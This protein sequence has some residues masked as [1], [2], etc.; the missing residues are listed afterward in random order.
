MK[1]NQGL[2]IDSIIQ[3]LKLNNP[4]YILTNKSKEIKCF[5]E[6]ANK[7]FKQNLE[8]DKSIH[9]YFKN[10][11]L[12]DLDKSKMFFVSSICETQRFKF[13]SLMINDLIAFVFSPIV[14]YLKPITNYHLS[15]NDIDSINYLSEYVFLAETTIG[16]L[17]DYDNIN[18]ILKKQNKELRTKNKLIESLGRFP[19]ENPNPV[20]RI[21]RNNKVV[22]KNESS[23]YFTEILAIDNNNNIQ[24][25][26][27]TQAINVCY[28]QKEKSLVT[29]IK[30][31]NNIFNLTVKY[32]DYFNDFNL[33]LTD[34]SEYHKK[35]S[36]LKIFYEEILDQIPVEVAVLDKNLQFVYFNKKA[37]KDDT[38]RNYM[39]GKTDEDYYKLKNNSKSFV[40]KRSQKIKEAFNKRNT[41]NWID[42]YDTKKETIYIQRE[43]K[44]VID[45]DN[46]VKRLVG[47]G[48]DISKNIKYKQSLINNE[49]KWK[50]LVK[51]SSDLI[52]VLNTTCNIIFISN[53]VKNILGYNA[54]SLLNSSI[55]NI[56]HKDD[57]LAPEECCRNNNDTKVDHK[58]MRFKNSSGNF[59][60]LRIAMRYDDKI[61]KDPC[62]IINGQDI[63]ELKKAEAQRFMIGKASE[64]N[65]RRRIARDLH[66]GV[67]QYLATTVLYN[68]LLGKYVEKE[69]SEE[70][71]EIYKNSVKMLKKA[72]EEVRAVSHNIM[73]SS[74]KDFGFLKSI[75]QL[76]NDLK[77]S[78]PQIN[79]IY[80]NQVLRN[81]IGFSEHIN[82]NL[83][84][85]IQQIFNNCL[86]HGKPSI[87]RLTIKYDTSQLKIKILDNGLG[88]DT[89][90]ID[91]KKGIGMQ[92]IND[93]V[94][95]LG[96]EMNLV[97]KKNK[98]TIISI[99]IKDLNK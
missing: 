96:G 85:S 98:G 42:K 36:A 48:V 93:R 95:S 99:V 50:T 37:I 7:I 21:N 83:F 11:N 15:A 13:N 4:F 27:I 92:S 87:V 82:L 46:N 79:F 25:K 23:K 69:M 53:S 17:A 19:N 8:K 60:A 89:N 73:P 26:E 51:G 1:N 63:S 39:I 29:I 66:D 32:D 45:K 34:I 33:Y 72:T 77:K 35:S 3:L 38:T 70:G 20:I 22:F 16:S 28:K 94:I 80:N 44:P 30:I 18:N 91:Y 65:E 52:C 81:N 47:T 40:K 58:I 57:I 54:K 75:Q 10:L 24:C 14:N 55:K 6:A 64:E 90:V 76:I 5:S 97:S 59:T 9:H 31:K 88:F 71:K 74:M 49:K 43:L 41:P 56:I 12:I 68:S 67:G 78:N 61:Y 84:R 86:K 2:D 62:I